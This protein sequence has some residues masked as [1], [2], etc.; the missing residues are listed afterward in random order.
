MYIFVVNFSFSGTSEYKFHIGTTMAVP[1]GMSSFR[2][3][4]H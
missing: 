2:E 1:I 4:V 3:F